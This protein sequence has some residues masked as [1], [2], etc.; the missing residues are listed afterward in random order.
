MS[1]KYMCKN[2]KLQLLRVFDV[3]IKILQKVSIDRAKIRPFS[4]TYDIVTRSI[5]LYKGI[6]SMP[7]KNINSGELMQRKKMGFYTV[8]ILSYYLSHW[9]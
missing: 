6:I 9:L 8:R 4:S 1:N 2:R 3:I 5:S 7:S